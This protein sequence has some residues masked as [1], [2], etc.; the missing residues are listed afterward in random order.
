MARAF[1]LERREQHD[2][3]QRDNAP[4]DQIANGHRTSTFM[5]ANRAAF[6]QSLR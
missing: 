5:R 6:E 4:N 2:Q 3:E 1:G